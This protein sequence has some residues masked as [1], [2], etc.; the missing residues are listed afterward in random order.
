MAMI[1][2]SNSR[3]VTFGVN[4]ILTLAVFFLSCAAQLFTRVDPTKGEHYISTYT[5][6]WPVE[7][8]FLIA[9]MMLIFS[10]M[11]FVYILRQVWNYVFVRC[12][13]IQDITFSESYAITMLIFA[14]TLL[15]VG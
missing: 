3:R 13:G 14:I 6:D 4:A 7:I 10:V 5:R 12:I 1:E 2:K 9:V 8:S 15:F 11:L